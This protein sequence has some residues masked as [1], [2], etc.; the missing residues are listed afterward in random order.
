[1]PNDSQLTPSEQAMLDDVRWNNLNQKEREADQAKWLTEQVNK[2]GY[3]DM[4]EMTEQ[5]LLENV[6]WNN[7]DQDDRAAN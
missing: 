7:L 1:M 6:L 3:E 4:R 5:S 2:I